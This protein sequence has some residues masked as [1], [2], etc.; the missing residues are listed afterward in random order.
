VIKNEINKTKAALDLCLGFK[1]NTESKT[2]F[3]FISKTEFIETLLDLINSSG[4]HLYQSKNT[5]GIAVLLHLSCRFDV[6]QF[7]NFAIELYTRGVG[8]FNDYEITKDH[9]VI[10]WSSNIKPKGSFRGV[11]FVV[12]GSVRYVENTSLRFKVGTMDGMTW[13]KE[14]TMISKKIL[15]E[16]LKKESSLLLGWN[17]KKMKGMLERNYQ[18][19]LLFRTG[20]WKDK[21]SFFKDSWHYISIEKITI[22]KEGNVEITYWDYG[23]YKTSKITKFDFY[24]SILKTFVFS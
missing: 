24:S 7:T 10:K 19:I 3:N 1:R 20:A 9:N 17:I 6:V 5:C 18:V 4:E 14:I 2:V 16:H 21:G 8:Q 11:S 22:L 13:P 23:K 15:N 12:I